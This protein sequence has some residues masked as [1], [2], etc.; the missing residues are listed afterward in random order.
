MLFL[1]IL[2]LGKGQAQSM[3]NIL[4][5]VIAADRQHH[6][7]PHVAIDVDRQV[8]RAAA[9]VAD[10]HTHLA[11]LLGQHHLAGGQRVEH[12]LLDSTPAAPTHWRRLSTVA[13]EAVMMCAS[14]SRR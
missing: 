3:R 12:E 6:R 10:R 14:T 1:H 4:G 2:G 11:L 13:A 5:D 7:M 8:G 9:D